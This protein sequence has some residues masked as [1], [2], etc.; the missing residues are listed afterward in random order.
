MRAAVHTRYG[1]PSVVRVAEVPTPEPKD[2]EILV[3]IHASTVSSG[4][5]RLRASDIPPSFWL[6]ARLMFGL[7]RPRAG[8]LG[9]D[10]AGE[11]AAVGKDVTR[12]RVGDRVFGMK[13]MGSHAEYR[14][15]AEN[16]AIAPIPDGVSYEEAA[17]VPFGGTTALFFLRQAG[18]KAGQKVAVVGASG[19]VGVAF[20]QI[21]R[22][23]GAEVTGVCSTANVEMVRQLGA[24]HVV[25]YTR[26]NFAT[27]GP[28]DVIVDTVGAVKFGAVRHA[29]TEEGIFVAVVGGLGEM[30]RSALGGK[31]GRRL[32]SGVSNEAPE[33]IKTLS[34][35]LA[36]G[37]L[38]AVIDSRFPLDA[39][40]EAHARV[41]SK[42]KQG[43]VVLTMNHSSRQAA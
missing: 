32:I 12:Y 26:V 42:R 20:V 43:S 39:A 21:A 31:S 15:F 9:S 13:V 4:D 8:V 7:F 22:H 19:A 41:D 35:L 40:A 30:I 29:L 16:D 1:P 24:A 33:A 3:R 25:D 18:V 10:F 37:E 27:A 34:A 23:F 11:V 17:A 6:F 38:K 5:A 14:T 36:S 2:N 28:Y